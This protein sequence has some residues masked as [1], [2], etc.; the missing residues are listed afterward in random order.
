MIV[1]LMITIV[2]IFSNKYLLFIANIFTGTHYVILIFNDNI[3][4]HYDN[5]T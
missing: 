2:S 4:H 1:S 3:T 5:F